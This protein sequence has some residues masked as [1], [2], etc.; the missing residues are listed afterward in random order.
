M[1][2]KLFIKTNFDLCTG[3]GICTLVCSQRL[4]GGYNPHRALLRITHS[5]ENLY[6]HPVVCNQ[7]QNA[8][9]ANVCPV[10]A[11]GR[12]PVTYALEVDHAL[13]VGCDLCQRYCPIGVVGVDPDLKKAVKCDLCQ[14][15]P[16][17]VAACPTG[18]L[19]LAVSQ[20]AGAESGEAVVH[21]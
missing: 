3:C 7:C 1:A 15:D 16:R 21:G 10:G 9:C 13:C 6:H 18:A 4:L 14:G 5:Q 2:A 11:I 12:N 20:R 19:E 17:C 8:Y